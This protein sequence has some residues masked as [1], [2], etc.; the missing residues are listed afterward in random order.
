M[1]D[2]CHESDIPFMY[3]GCGNV[4]AIFED[5]IEMEVDVYHPLEAKAGFDV[6]DL[7]RK[8][9]HEIAFCGNMNVI[10][11]ADPI[12]SWHSYPT[13]QDRARCL[14]GPF[15]PSRCCPGLNQFLNLS[16]S[17]RTSFLFPF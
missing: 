13:P 12:I 3:H 10:D 2:T 9:G 11:W 6:V 7:R 17:L 16:L 4:H 5:F 15:A 8:Y 1:I 14:A